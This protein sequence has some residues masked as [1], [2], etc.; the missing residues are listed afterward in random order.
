[1]TLLLLAMLLQDA[2][3]V[4]ALVRELGAEDLETRSKAHQELVKLGRPALAAL[5]T[6]AEKGETEELRTRAKGAI[7]EIAWGPVMKSL[8][9]KLDEMNSSP[10]RVFELVEDDAQDVKSY[11]PGYRVFFARVKWQDPRMS[12]IVV[13]RAYILERFAERPFD[14]LP[15]LNTAL[16]KTILRINTADDAKK[17]VAFMKRLAIPSHMTVGDEKVE[18][19]EDG[20]RAFRQLGRQVQVYTLTLAAGVLRTVDYRIETS[21]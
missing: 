17:F 21:K 3:R 11:L 14:A 2:D 6:L 7:H 15:G 8:Q 19:T 4:E 20:Y 12:S 1:M 10:S 16:K 5:E 9:A 13:P 18:K